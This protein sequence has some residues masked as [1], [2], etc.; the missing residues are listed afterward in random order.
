MQVASSGVHYG[1]YHT[2]PYAHPYP[3]TPQW[4]RADPQPRSFQNINYEVKLQ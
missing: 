2:D 3:H 4:D 1:F